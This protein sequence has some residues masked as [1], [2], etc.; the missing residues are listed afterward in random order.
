MPKKAGSLDGP[1]CAYLMKQ[2][3]HNRG[4]PRSWGNECSCEVSKWSVKNYWHESVNSDFQWAK[5]E[6]VKK[7]AIFGE[8]DKTQNLC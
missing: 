1:L 7:I 6:N 4:C 2:N 3:L 8:S 5:L